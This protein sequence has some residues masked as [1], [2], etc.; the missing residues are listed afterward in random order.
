MK[1][2]WDSGES[3]AAALMGSFFDLGDGDQGS[4]PHVSPLCV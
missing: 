3:P 4:G 1:P 2:R